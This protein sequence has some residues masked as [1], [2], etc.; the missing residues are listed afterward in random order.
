MSATDPAR[1]DNLFRQARALVGSGRLAD[2]LPTLQALVQIDPRHTEVRNALAVAAL[3]SGDL[4]AARNHLSVAREVS[5]EDALTLNQWAQL[6]LFEGDE[7]GAL[8]AYAAL[9]SRHPG[10]Y[11]SRLPY[12]KLLEGSGDA[13][14]AALHY[15]RAV[16][17]A[18]RSGR[19]LSAESTP[20]GIQSD[21]SRAMAVVD[22]HRRGLCE[23]VLAQLVE[24][25]GPTGL[26]RVA[27]YVAIQLGDARYAPQDTRQKPTSFPFPDLPQSPYL[28]KRAVPEIEALEASTADVLAELLTVMDVDEGHQDVFAEQALAQAFLRSTRGPA[29]WDGFYFHRHGRRHD[30]NALACPKTAAAVD[31]LP[32]AR[33]PGHGPEVLFSTLGPGTHLMPHHGVT[34]AR[35]VGHLPLIVPDDCALR[36][37]GIEHHWR[38][39][40]V[41]LFDDTYLHEAWNRSPQRRVVMIF[42]V[43]HPELTPVECAAVQ[44]LQ[45]TLGDFATRSASLEQR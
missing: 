4:G 42:D 43:W 21:I 12:A 39:G 6:L 31:R 26:E 45:E 2:A 32:L 44:M 38:V 9:L 36:V 20:P 10:L 35:V 19:W 7:G 24:R 18:Q 17:D 40:E 13:E 27:G 1:F 34:N 11:A 37:A 3:Q 15:F 29:K 14:G 33:V 28:E 30:E 41:V 8:R 25:F 23:R 22:R 5:P 16:R